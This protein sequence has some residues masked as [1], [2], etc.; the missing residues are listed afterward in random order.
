M[1][2]YLSNKELTDFLNQ[3]TQQ[4]TRY[5]MDELAN[6]TVQSIDAMK[7]P[8]NQFIGQWCIDVLLGNGWKQIDTGTELFYIK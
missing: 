2:G 7:F 5:T 3:H 4:K 6:M 8:P 1:T